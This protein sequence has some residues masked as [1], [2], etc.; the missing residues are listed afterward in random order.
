MDGIARLSKT[1]R[2]ELFTGTAAKKQLAVAA[3]E[4]DFW[5]CWTLSQLFSKSQLKD[6]LVFK[7]GTSLSK[8]YH[9]IERFSEDIDLIMD[10]RLLGYNEDAPFS[11]ISGKQEKRLLKEMVE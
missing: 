3:V 9:L 2:E 4:K 6:S 8:A 1:G 10:W 7:G 5:V 11:R